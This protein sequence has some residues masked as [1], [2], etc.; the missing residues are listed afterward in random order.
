MEEVREFLR[1]AELA[2]LLGVTPSR[3]YQLIAAGE[4]PSTRIG[5]SLRVPRRALDRWLELLAD[6]ATAAIRPRLSE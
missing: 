6:R 4:I 5:G 1:P 3:I 2:P